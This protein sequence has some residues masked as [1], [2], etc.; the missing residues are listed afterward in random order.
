MSLM[1]SFVMASITIPENIGTNPQSMLLLLPLVVA[2]AVIYKVT[3][4][5]K[6][7][8][9]S[10]IREVVILSGSIVIFITIIAIALFAFTWLITE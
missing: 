6:I 3:K 8:A 2:I 10:F 4:M 1:A 9:A 5:P 7:T